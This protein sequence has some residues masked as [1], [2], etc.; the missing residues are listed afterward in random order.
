MKEMP[1]VKE[2]ALNEYPIVFYSV[3]ALV[4]IFVLLK[5]FKKN[6]QE[7]KIEEKQDEKKAKK[8]VKKEK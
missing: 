8:N 3:S 2:L 1:N 6:P 5:L 4:V 7:T